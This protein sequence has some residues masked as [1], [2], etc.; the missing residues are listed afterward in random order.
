[1]N[2]A[3]MKFGGTSVQDSAALRRLVSIVG[4]ERGARVVVVSALA[5][6]TDAL[7]ALAEGGLPEAEARG[8]IQHL[9]ERHETI[10]RDL[11][12]PPAGPRLIER[13]RLRFA[14]VAAIVCTA[15]GRVAPRDRDAVLAIG[16]LASSEVV[17]AVLVAAGI[18]ARWL[19][20]R[21]VIVTNERFGSAVPDATAIRQAAAS[22]LNPALECGVVPVLGGFVGA[23]VAGLTTTLGRGGSDYSAALLGAALDASQI[24]IWTDVDGVLTADPRSVARTEL[25]RALSFGEAYELARFGAK[26]L[27]W[28]TLEPAA[29]QDIPVHVLN[30]RTPDIRTGTMITATRAGG[31]HVAGLAHCSD[32]AVLDV[33][34][35][36]VT[37]SHA[38]VLAA[39]A[40]LER[41][42]QAVTVVSLS[43]T[44]L[45]VTSADGALL[46]DGATVL[47]AFGPS[48]VLTGRSIVAIVGDQIA[49]DPDVWRIVRQQR[50][51]PIE[52][53]IPAQ[54]GQ[55]LLCVTSA[56]QGLDLLNALHAEFFSR[57]QARR[58]TSARPLSAE[59]MVG[60][61]SFSGVSQ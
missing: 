22:I 6:V 8:T 26:V 5:G 9:C 32:V 54:S 15:Q 19:D 57:P 11:V 40:W 14:A 34:A 24:Q 21:Q 1:M 42:A 36:G 7:S 39:L 4:A 20:A 51:Q 58:P 49:V 33:R 53:A 25:V 12:G 18:P 44:R 55:A 52:L 59:T 29:A 48:A 2:L 46:R 27:H 41:A 50:P 3:V 17:A 43:P 60:A 38:F 30:A 61:Q 56:R 28:G 37:G 35:R 10:V 31:R 45:T 13:V 23:S 16:E 47:R